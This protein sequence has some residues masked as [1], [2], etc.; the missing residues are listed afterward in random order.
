MGTTSTAEV[1]AG[2]RDRA[3]ELLDEIRRWRLRQEV[4]EANAAREI[5]RITLKFQRDIDQAQAR[6]GEADKELRA[7]M[8][9]ETGAIFE[10][11]DTA[12][13]EHGVLTHTVEE[14][15]RIQNRARAIEI[16]KEQGWTEAVLVIEK[17]NRPVVEAWPEDRLVVI[18]ANR[19]TK[20]VFGYE[21]I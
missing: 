5:R 14:K 11:R 6:I 21:V 12:T 19:R 2:A 15:L 7:L 9:A 16:L 18:G 17:I 1:R 13:L 4:L 8:K 3:E 20:D 10:G